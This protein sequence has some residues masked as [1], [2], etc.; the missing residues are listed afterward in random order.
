MIASFARGLSGRHVEAT[1]AD[2][3]GNQAAISKSTVSQVVGDF[4]EISAPAHVR[5]RR[6]GEITAQPVGRLARGL[7]RFGTT[8]PAAGAGHQTLLSHQL[9][10]GVLAQPPPQR[11]QVRNNPRRPVRVAVAGEQVGDRRR[12][13]CPSFPVVTD[14]P[15]GTCETTPATLLALGKTPPP[16]CRALGPLRRDHGGRAHRRIAPLTQRAFLNCRSK[17]RRSVASH[18][19]HGDVSS[20]RGEAQH[21]HRGAVLLLKCSQLVGFSAIG[22]R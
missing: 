9:G 18:T 13:R 22:C 11:P 2:A 16:R 10:D 5:P 1:P 17:F 4:G 19:P 12:Q 20:V 15:C 14:L 8:T 3:L 21:R 6:W 7:V